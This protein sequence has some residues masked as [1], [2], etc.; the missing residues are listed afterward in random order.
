MR[1]ILIDD[2]GN[3]ELIE[4]LPYDPEKGEVEHPVLTAAKEYS[5]TPCGNCGFVCFAK[6]SRH[7]HHDCVYCTK[8]VDN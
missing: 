8:E 4:D 2:R 1:I 3:V 7:D 6:D 5:F